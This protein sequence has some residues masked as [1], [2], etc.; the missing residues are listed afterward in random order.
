MSRLGFILIILTWAHSGCLLAQRS[1]VTPLFQ[2]EKPLSIRLGY[3]FKTVKQNTTDSV[4]YPTHLYYKNGHD[5]WD[6]LSISVRARGNFRRK[7]CYFAPMRIKIK[8]KEAKGTS[9]EGNQYLKLV[10]PCQDG[11]T[12]HDLI[13][14]EYICYQL[15]EA[16][17]PY[18]FNT[19]LLDITLTDQKGNRNKTYQVPGFFIEDDDLVAKRFHGK[20]IDSLDLHP[21]L[22]HDT[23]SVTH[24]FFE[25]MI[26][27]TDFST[28]FHHNTKI[29]HI[30]P[31]KYIPVAYDFDMAGFVNAPYATFRETLDITSVRERVYR[32]F[33]R[34]EN[35]LQFVRG[36]YI[37]N[38]PNVMN[39]LDRYKDFQSDKEFEGMKKYIL[40]FFDILESDGR[41]QTEIVKAC[42]TR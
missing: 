41:F 3:S 21:L 2:D 20:I 22:L 34:N 38:K 10:L 40:G 13:R 8:K 42:R 26:A 19:R 36:E 27:N 5:Q 24:D 6:S 32:G 28:T 11:S 31:K 29:I 30:K 25:L 14:K 17:T 33:C 12:Y 18:T 15:Y 4:Y 9:F 39:V 35:V 37:K 7:Y 16:S 1:N 23:S